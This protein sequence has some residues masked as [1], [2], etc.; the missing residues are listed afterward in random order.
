M[1]APDSYVT[2]A[3]VDTSV[4]RP[5]LSRVTLVAQTPGAGL[6]FAGSASLI[7]WCSDCPTSSKYCVSHELSGRLTL[8]RRA[9]A[10]S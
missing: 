2:L 8:V 9:Q 5:P 10:V 7:R 1:A 6:V 4:T 3:G